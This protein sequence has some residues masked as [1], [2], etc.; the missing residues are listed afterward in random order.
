MPN[1][2]G[3]AAA[4]AARSTQQ[5]Q[6]QEKAEDLSNVFGYVDETPAPAAM[7]RRKQQQQQQQQAGTTAVAVGSAMDMPAV[8]RATQRS[9]TQGGAV[10]SAS[11]RV[12]SEARAVMGQKLGLQELRAQQEALEQAAKGVPEPRPS[13]VSQLG[14]DNPQT[15][16]GLA[17]YV[18]LFT[19]TEVRQHYPMSDD[20]VNKLIELAGRARAAE[21]Q[22]RISSELLNKCQ[23]SLRLILGEQTFVEIL[24]HP[25]LP[26]SSSIRK[27]H[28]ML[29]DKSNDKYDTGTNKPPLPASAA[30]ARA[31]P[32]ATASNAPRRGRP[33]AS[34]A[35][36]NDDTRKT[37]KQ[38]TDAS[39][40][41]AT[42]ATKPTTAAAAAAA[43]AAQKPSQT[44]AAPDPRSS[45]QPKTP[46][47]G[48][49]AARPPSVVATATANRANTG[50]TTT[51]TNRGLS[52]ERTSR[53]F[54]DMAN[55]MKKVHTT[56]RANGNSHDNENSPGGSH[57]AGVSSDFM[58]LMDAAIRQIILKI[59]KRMLKLSA[60]RRGIRIRNIQ[61]KT[62]LDDPMRAVAIIEREEKILEKTLQREEDDASARTSKKDAE[63]SAPTD[64]G[65]NDANTMALF[66]SIAGGAGG[67][68]GAP[69]TMG[70][71]SGGE[72][73]NG[74]GLD[75]VSP[76][77]TRKS[78]AAFVAAISAGDNPI[79]LRDVECALEEEFATFLCSRTRRRI[80]DLRIQSEF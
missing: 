68:G 75:L 32:A 9:M 37:K 63:M 52:N 55:L 17:E 24:H 71:A 57:H 22:E 13:V 2:R 5:Q 59:V 6:Q 8:T 42:S 47:S 3:A 34:A 46:R 56:L 28:I 30:V 35:D 7:T 38:K 64:D 72:G 67:A 53:S 44:H 54:C 51:T 19:S 80:E 78:D 23:V 25:T 39:R 58:Q 26:T 1:P 49:A 74:G 61:N 69:D 15:E 66:Q 10:V 50:A 76:T 60:H 18:L 48:G 14:I 41:A 31:E 62:K 43:A 12:K 20:Q 27:M 21:M 73:D 65:G 16:V 40:A 79:R 36:G 45:Q 77:P 11:T 29:S 4:R 70:E 33:P